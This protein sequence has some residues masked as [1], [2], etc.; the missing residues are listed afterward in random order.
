MWD[1]LPNAVYTQEG[2][3]VTSQVTQETKVSPWMDGALSGNQSLGQLLFLPTP[4]LFSSLLTHLLKTLPS[5]PSTCSSVS[6]CFQAA[7]SQP[8]HDGHNFSE[9]RNKPL[10]H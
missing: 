5:E 2:P 1:C 6:E 8:L 10:L 7:Q 9:L 4:S 3:L